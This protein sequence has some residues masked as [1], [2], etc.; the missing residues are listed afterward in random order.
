MWVTSC[1]Q[2]LRLWP[3]GP[4]SLDAG[5]GLSLFQECFG[6]IRSRGHYTSCCIAMRG[7]ELHALTYYVSATQL[8]GYCGVCSAFAETSV[9]NVQRSAALPLCKK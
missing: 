9:R 4:H 7:L 8:H 2:D 3:V 6:C 1:D 5:L